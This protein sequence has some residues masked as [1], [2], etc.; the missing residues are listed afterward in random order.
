[1]LLSVLQ[2]ETDGATDILTHKQTNKQTDV[3]TLMWAHI[4]GQTDR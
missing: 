1:M 2:S 4:D 3:H